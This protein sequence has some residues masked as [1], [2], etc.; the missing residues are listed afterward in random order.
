MY[1]MHRVKLMQ[2]QQAR[3]GLPSARFLADCPPHAAVSRLADLP[4]HAQVAT[5][6]RLWLYGALGDT[7]GYLA[8]L[9]KAAIAR[10]ETHVDVLMPGFT[11]LQVLPRGR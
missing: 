1:R 3:P 7:R 6:T 5:D 4:V 9:V 2:K 10:A 11:H 8:D